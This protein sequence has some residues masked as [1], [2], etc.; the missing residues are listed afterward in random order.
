MVGIH[1]TDLVFKFVCCHQDEHDADEDKKD[2]DAEDKDE[3]DEDAK[4][5]DEKVEDAEDNDDKYEDAEDK[6]EKDQGAKDKDE[7]DEDDE[8]AHFLSK[9]HR[10]LL[11]V[12]DALPS[13][14]LLGS[15]PI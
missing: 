9:G 6:D 7:K 12:C 3:E 5:K 11:H 15:N 14:M 10:L 2:E 8:A 13:G 1:A 4:D